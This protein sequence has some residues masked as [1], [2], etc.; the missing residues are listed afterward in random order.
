[1][2]KKEESKP[3]KP[4]ENITMLVASGNKMPSTKGYGPPSRGRGVG[5]SHPHNVTLFRC[6]GDPVSDGGKHHR[7]RG[8]PVGEGEKMGINFLTRADSF[9][10][11]NKKGDLVSFYK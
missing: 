5:K 10:C 8:R 7:F 6:G 1:V 2:Q 11:L 9:L 4:S 3:K